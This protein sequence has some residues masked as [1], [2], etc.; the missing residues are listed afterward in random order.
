MSNAILGLVFWEA[1]CIESFSEQPDGSLVLKLTE[2]P[3]TP[4]RCG[5]CREAC[6]C[7]MN[8]AVGKSESVTGLTGVFGWMYR[9]VAWIAT[10]AERGWLR[11]LP[12]LTVDPV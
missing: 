3:E 1:H 8:V 4:A 12:G 9:S 7:T 5:C 11:I 10:T 6:V 2:D